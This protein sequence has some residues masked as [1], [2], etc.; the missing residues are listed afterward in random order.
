MTKIIIS[1]I[2]STLALPAY[3]GLVE[4]YKREQSKSKKVQKTLKKQDPNTIPE[5]DFKQKY[6]LWREYAFNELGNKKLIIAIYTLIP[7][8]MALIGAFFN[9]LILILLSIIAP[10]IRVL[11]IGKL[12]QEG[13]AK[14]LDI[15][16]KI[17]VFKRAKMGLIDTSSTAYSYKQ[18][19]TV[20][21]WNEDW[22]PRKI[23]MV[24]PVTFS[25]SNRLTFLNSFCEKFPYKGYWRVDENDGWDDENNTVALNWQKFLSP[26]ERFFVER[27]LEFKRGA[28]G[29]SNP[30]STLYTYY[31]EI[32]DIEWDETK[33]PV[34]LKLT[35]PIL[36]DSLQKDTF[37]DKM[38]STFGRGRPWEVDDTDE[39]R[40][41]WDTTN[42]I[43]YLRLQNPLPNLALWNE[44]YLLNDI[45]QWSFFPLG[46][47]SRGGVPF[48]EPDGKEVRLVGFD[49]N[50]AQGKYLKKSHIKYGSD[51]M[52][53]PHTLG[54]G[55]T[56]GGKSVVQ[57]DIIISCL[58]RSEKWFLII[59]DMKRVEGA[60]Y[61]KYGVPVATTFED[62]A[63]LL[64]YAQTVMM[65]RFEEMELRGI[66]NW[67]D[68]PP[69]EQGSAIMINVDEMAELLAPLKGKSEET[70]EK[71][72]YQG[73]CQNALE[74]IAR[75]GRAAQVHLVCFAQRPSSD[76]IPMQIRQNAPTKVACGSLPSTISGMLFNSS[77][78]AT[79]PSKPQGRIG[80]QIHSSPPFKAQGFFADEGWLDEYIEQHNLPVNIQGSNEM[81]TIYQENKNKVE[82]EN[83]LMGI[84]MSEDDYELLTSAME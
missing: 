26:K 56:G 13:F 47:G 38:S 41:G 66:N 59:I 43:A 2:I 74:S 70:Q 50:G 63:C 48:T 76:V 71:A 27:F 34:A 46:I 24:V 18:E 42:Q 5:I 54:A 84:E 32:D 20:E 8:L 35:L 6:K 9:W 73:Q 33:Q 31:N 3:F 55:V 61:R 57:R 60:M 83:E 14:K 80:L 53:S 52:P 11:V 78:G 65:E 75:L 16:N 7:L 82:S 25:V 81:A 49:V 51:L 77:F 79:V 21:K 23:V 37:L 28:M 36:Y 68:M 62:A 10:F 15:I 19:F 67:A 1:L 12:V 29:L 30:N 72:E 64:S 39:S 17:L 69:E 4:L 45:V 22:E 44:R 58:L 40:E